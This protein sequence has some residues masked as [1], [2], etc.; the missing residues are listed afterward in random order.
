[1]NKR[2]I[3]IVENETAVY[4]RLKHCL[5]TE[6]F[7]A[8]WTRTARE[9]LHR[10][11]A[12]Q[13]DLVLLDLNLPDMEGRKALDWFKTMHPF[14]ALVVLTDA[15]VRAADA[16][17]ASASAWLEK[18]VDGPRLSETVTRLLAESQSARLTRLM[19]ELYGETYAEENQVRR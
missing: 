15:P 16:T 5:D 13:F 18:P 2:R 3:L 8:I 17:T 9:A 1:M 4:N 11:L 7:E 14:L 19:D 12:E 6:A 10:S